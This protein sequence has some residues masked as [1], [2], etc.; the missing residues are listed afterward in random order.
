MVTSNI[1]DYKMGAMFEEDQRPN[2]A[3]ECTPKRKDEG[4]KT[5]RKNIDKSDFFRLS[6]NKRQ[7]DEDLE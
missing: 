4:S 3:D 6:G 1:V 2:S 7:E 5:A